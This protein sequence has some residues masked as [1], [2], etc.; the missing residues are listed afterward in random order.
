MLSLHAFKMIICQVS[1]NFP[2]S[3]ASSTILLILACSPTGPKELSKLCRE[4]A[5]EAEEAGP[6]GRGSVEDVGIGASR[7][8]TTIRPKDC[9]G[10]AVW[11]K[12]AKYPW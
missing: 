4:E 3:H 12:L 1:Y 7:R 8:N 10:S 6:S 9:A 2:P 11:A 5:D